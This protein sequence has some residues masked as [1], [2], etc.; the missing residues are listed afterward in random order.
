LSSPFSGCHRIF[1]SFPKRTSQNTLNTAMKL[2]RWK[3]SIK[4]KWEN[5]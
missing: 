5:Q 2:H 3:R 1:F 4:R